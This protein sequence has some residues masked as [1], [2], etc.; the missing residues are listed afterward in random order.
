MAC[1]NSDFYNFG[2]FRNLFSLCRRRHKTIPDR[3]C[4][5]KSNCRNVVD[6]S[7]CRSKQ[8]DSLYR[9]ISCTFHNHRHMDS[10]GR[11]RN[12][13]YI[14][15]NIRDHHSLPCNGCLDILG[16]GLAHIDR[17]DTLV[18]QSCRN[19]HNESCPDELGGSPHIEVVGACC[20]VV[21]APT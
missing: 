2:R 9:R 14:H 21:S 19:H 1:V 8:F 15:D 17:T 13:I 12:R 11:H 20:L 16:N 3:W 6:H 5:Q 18:P 7:L 10:P 4:R